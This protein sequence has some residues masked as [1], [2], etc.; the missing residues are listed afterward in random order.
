[1]KASD[2]VVLLRQEE[3]GR[4]LGLSPQ[5]LANHRSRGVGI[6]FVRLGRS[7]RYLERDVKEYLEKNRVSTSPNAYGDA[8]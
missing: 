1:M 8:R 3:V 7:V 5:T 6:P 4:L 2:Q